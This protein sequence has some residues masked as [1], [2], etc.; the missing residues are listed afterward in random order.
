M[1]LRLHRNG[2][3]RDVNPLLND[4]ARLIH[5]SELI[6]LIVD[7]VG[8][9]D[10]GVPNLLRGLVYVEAGIFKN[11][12]SP[13]NRTVQFEEFIRR[14]SHVVTYGFEIEIVEVQRKG[15]LDER[16]VIESNKNNR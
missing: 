13:I 8:E 3:R 11:R 9:V 6:V 2:N 1:T 5:H 4:N 15:S 7:G 10:N 12:I 14:P 16:I